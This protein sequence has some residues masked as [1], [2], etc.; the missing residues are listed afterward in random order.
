MI[1]ALLLSGW[2]SARNVTLWLQ[3]AG[4]GHLQGNEANAF[5]FV[6]KTNRSEGLH[7]ADLDYFCNT[8]T[9]VGDDTKTDCGS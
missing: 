1:S 7:S 2:C 3:A 8:Y 5:I 4:L 9:L 6:I